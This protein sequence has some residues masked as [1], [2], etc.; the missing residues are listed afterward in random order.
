MRVAEGPEVLAALTNRRS[1]LWYYVALVYFQTDPT[2][3]LPLTA[4]LIDT[5]IAEL[6]TDVAIKP[7]RDLKAQY[8][9]ELDQLIR[10]TSNL[11]PIRSSPLPPAATNERIRILDLMKVGSV[12]AEHISFLSYLEGRMRLAEDCC[13]VCGGGESEPPDLIVICSKC[14]TAVHMRCYGLAA[15][16][17]GDWLCDA[18]RIGIERTCGLCFQTGAA[19]KPTIQ[20]RDWPYSAQVQHQDRMWTHLFCAQSIGAAFL[21]PA[22]K[23]LI[24]LSAVSL[25]Y[26]ER[27]C[28]LCTETKGAVVPCAMCKS[29]F[30][31]ECWRKKLCPRPPWRRILCAV[32][33]KQISQQTIL[34]GENKVVNEVLV[35]CKQISQGK[36][37]I[38]GDFTSEEKKNLL[39]ACDR[40]LIASYPR[41]KEGFS[42]TMSEDMRQ[43]EVQQPPPFN[44]LSPAALKLSALTLPNRTPEQ[45]YFCYL[46][47]YPGLI[48]QLSG[49]REE[50]TADY[51]PIPIARKK[52]RSRRVPPSLA[53]FPLGQIAGR[54]RRQKRK[55][56]KRR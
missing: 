38:N 50:L 21:L 8:K 33:S 9:Q 4:S 55:T 5:L 12:Q 54:R 41:R 45:C 22:S 26:W 23:D 24:D 15:L 37:R 20:S 39:Q 28:R 34:M 29:A 2:L 25:A 16:P 36:R 44:L 6:L 19:L 31:P 42:I 51:F 14:E 18:C 13:C 35:F 48:A 10:F 3:H 7:I 46:S 47:L 17:D 32:H 11:T 43:M 52:R 56:R 27:K 1:A 40:L 49:S 30:H 53:R